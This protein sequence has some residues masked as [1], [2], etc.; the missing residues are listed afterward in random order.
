MRSNSTKNFDILATSL[1]VVII[2]DS[3]TKLFS[4]LYLAKFLDTSAK[5]LFPCTDSYF[6]DS[7]LFFNEK[8]D[9]LFFR[10]KTKGN[11]LQQNLTIF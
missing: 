4:N 10:N 7:L 8:I 2:I 6:T 11:F 1:S 9:L 3:P 5:S